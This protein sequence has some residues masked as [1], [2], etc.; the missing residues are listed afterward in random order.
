[1]VSESRIGG[2]VRRVFIYCGIFSCVIITCIT[3][4]YS[5]NL[6]E[7]DGVDVLSRGTTWVPVQKD[8][9]NIL[10]ALM[11]NSLQQRYRYVVHLDHMYE[12]MSTSMGMSISMNI[13]GTW[14]MIHHISIDMNY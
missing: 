9:E 13:D 8:S 4:I 14:L 10:W 2:A 5:N 11:P 1:M 7:R 6:T 12:Y 3:C